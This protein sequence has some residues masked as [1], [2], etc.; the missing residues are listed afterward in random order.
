MDESKLDTVQI[1]AIPSNSLVLPPIIKENEVMFISCKDIPAHDSPGKKSPAKD[2]L[3]TFGLQSKQW[4]NTDIAAT[5][6]QNQA[7]FPL[8]Y[9]DD[10]AI[11]RATS[12]EAPSAKVGIYKLKEMSLWE[13]I[14]FTSETVTPVD[15]KNCRCVH[16]TRYIVLVSIFKSEITFHIH[17]YASQPWSS[18]KF[19]L[20]TTKT[21]SELQSCAIV[22]HAIFCSVKSTEINHQQK[23]T[24][25]KLMLEDV[26]EKGKSLNNSDFESICTYDSSVLQCNLFVATG[27]VMMMKVI[28]NNSDNKSSTLELSSLNDTLFNFKRQ[29]KDYA[30]VVKLLSVIPLSTATYNN[31]VLIAYYDNR[32][33][34]THSEIFYLPSPTWN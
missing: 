25:F 11:I 16:S 21:S 32:F 14:P 24:I 23:V 20:L 13:L 33:C 26:L 5:S 29:K 4:K 12:L 19:S 30:F 28:V 9:K 3:H 31:H 17:K 6:S 1:I 27:E 7:A 10:I 15:F 8:L 2:T 22:H 34:K 18:I